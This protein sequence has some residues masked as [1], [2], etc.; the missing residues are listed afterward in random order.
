MTI[1]ADS[2]TLEKT[3]DAPAAT[4]T[5]AAEAGDTPEIPEQYRTEDGTA[6]LGKLLE[7]VTAADAEPEGAADLPEEAGGYD[8][9]ALA[10]FEL[11]GGGKGSL[12]AEDPALQDFLKEMHAAGRGQEEVA[13]ILKHAPKLVES[14]V[15]GMT[16]ASEEQVEAAIAELGEGAEARFNTI[17]SGLS[18][19]VGE[20]AAN[21]IMGELRS[22]KSFEAVERLLEK[23]EGGPGDRSQDGDGKSPQRSLGERFFGSKE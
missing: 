16:S 12:N 4:D 17:I 11:E 23:A 15:K 20:D 18:A 22:V 14:V 7:R 10:E 1:E 5:P 21:A 13:G 3:D 9:S 19:R 6:D 8:L 2:P